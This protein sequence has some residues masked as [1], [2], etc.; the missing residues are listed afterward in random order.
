MRMRALLY[1]RRVCACVEISELFAGISEEV[2]SRCTGKYE[3]SAA[4]QA[5][6]R[7]NRGRGETKSAGAAANEVT[8]LFSPAFNSIMNSD[9]SLPVFSASF[10]FSC[11][12]LPHTLFKWNIKMR[13]QK[14][15]QGALIHQMSPK[16]PERSCNSHEGFHLRETPR[17][18]CETILKLG[19][20][21]VATPIQ[22]C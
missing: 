19:R 3:R 21:A 1:R 15:E 5:R 2:A 8:E 16:H 10:P 14:A 11:V 20:H 17:M 6:E 12:C 9:L 13:Q 22:S 4:E 18:F 7:K